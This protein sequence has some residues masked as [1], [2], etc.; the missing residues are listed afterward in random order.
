MED[1]ADVAEMHANALVKAI[2]E[3]KQRHEDMERTKTEC[4]EK[5][6]Q[7]KEH[8]QEAAKETEMLDKLADMFGN[9]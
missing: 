2:E 1:D 9:T 8:L 5:A 3:M 7:A 6:A 4:H